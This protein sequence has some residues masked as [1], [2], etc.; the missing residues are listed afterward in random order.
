MEYENR[1]GS[2]GATGAALGTGIAG[3]SL[4]VLNAMGGI[5]GALLGNRAAAYDGVC[6]ENCPVNRFELEQQKA[7][8]EKDSQIAQL[9]GE[10]YADS[11]GQGV[12]RELRALITDMN[13]K[14]NDRFTNVERRLAEEAV[15]QQKTEDSILMVNERIDCVKNTIMAALCRE[16]DERKCADN[17][18][19]TYTN[20]TFYPKMT[21]NVE[22]GT[23]TTAQ[24]TYN[25]LPIQ[26]GCGCGK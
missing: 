16:T 18:I 21:A 9:R 23:T 19:V 12:Y 3:L 10:K 7:M 26:C 25:P 24:A 14:N 5:G 20:A 17:T 6:S 22:T 13:E 1:Y 11:V 8:A 4:G 2:K 15:I